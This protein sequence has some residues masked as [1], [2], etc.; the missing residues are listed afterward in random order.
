MS[1]G[2]KTHATPQPFLT[3]WKPPL[4][5]IDL[6]FGQKQKGTPLCVVR[7]EIE[8]GALLLAR[9]DSSPETSSSFVLRLG[10]KVPGPLP[11]LPLSWVGRAWEGRSAP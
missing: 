2:G 9:L 10:A 7:R 4:P 3:H 8:I 6:A 1:P 11:R 5:S